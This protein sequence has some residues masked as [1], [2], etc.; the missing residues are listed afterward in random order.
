[1]LSKVYIIVLCF[2]G[3]ELTVECID[4]IFDQNYP[5]IEI[6][7]VD[8]G[9]SDETIPI[10]SERYPKV[11]WVQNQKNLGYA[12]GNNKG[13]EYALKAGAD[14]VMLVNNDTRL[15]QSCV[16]TL[17][18][19]LISEP[20]RGI[21]GPMVYTWDKDQTISSAGGRI[22]WRNADAENVGMGEKDHGQFPER[23][24]DFVNGCGIMASR[25]VITKT[26]GLDAKYFMYWEETDWCLRIKKLGFDVV[27][28]PSAIMDHKQTIHN[29]A[30]KPT[31]LYYMTRN[32]FLFFSRHSPAELKPI[33]LLRATKGTLRGILE[34]RQSGK[35]EHARAMQTA[36]FHAVSGRW[37]QADPKIWA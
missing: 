23:R 9:S 29:V 30:L 31:T 13:M 22:D 27:F 28:K 24:V 18:N 32:R 25:E 5:E 12:L 2:N 10:V 21:I 4:S 7:V 11:K 6:C 16:Q 20:K 37:G 3:V 35:F 19:G 15:H 1:V 33:A 26:S 8:N 34:N 14:I 36:L 17:V